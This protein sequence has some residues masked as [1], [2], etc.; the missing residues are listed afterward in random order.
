M[1]VVVLGVEND[2]YLQ[3]KIKI[4]KCNK[5]NKAIFDCIHDTF[6]GIDSLEKFI[7]YSSYIQPVYLFSKEPDLTYER[8]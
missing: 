7:K 4:D 8:L 1:P 6:E 5:T 3:N 2:Y